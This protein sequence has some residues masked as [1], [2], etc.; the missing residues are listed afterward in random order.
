M[1]RSLRE[2]HPEAV[3][4]GGKGQKY[5]KN[6]A[7]NGSCCFGAYFFFLYLLF[8]IF[9]KNVSKLCCWLPLCIAWDMRAYLCVYGRERFKE[10]ARML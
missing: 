10:A 9:F 7:E 4:T 3:V 1:L 6:V 5:L 2:Q 8:F